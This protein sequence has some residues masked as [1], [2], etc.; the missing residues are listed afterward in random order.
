MN[1]SINFYATVW[2]KPYWKKQ[3][4]RL[5]INS[6][7]EAARTTSAFFKATLKSIPREDA[8]KRHFKSVPSGIRLGTV[9]SLRHERTLCTQPAYR[10]MLLSGAREIG[11][12]V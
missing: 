7:Y 6:N 2:I 4:K 9:P 8:L 12:D 3:D 10:Q 11:N 5:I 1:C